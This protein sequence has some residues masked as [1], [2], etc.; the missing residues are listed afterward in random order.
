MSRPV[1]LHL[2]PLE[3][4][5]V[6]FMRRNPATSYFPEELAKEL[7]HSVNDVG[8]A[9]AK[10]ERLGLVAAPDTAAGDDAYNITPAAESI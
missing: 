7:G 6:H 10:L 1:E 8:A 9:L 3:L 4:Q 5:I 2:G